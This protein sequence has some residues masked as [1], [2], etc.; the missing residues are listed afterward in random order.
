MKRA[1]ENSLC[2]GLYEDERQIGFARIVTDY[3]RHACHC[4]VFVL[5]THRGKGLGKWLV[6]CA[7]ECPL[8]AGVRSI[9][10]DT[11][12]AQGLY[13]QFGFKESRA[14]GGQMVRRFDM[15]WYRPEMMVE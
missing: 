1:I 9:K 11:R 13:A 14:T 2:F 8:I 3:A 12:D 6:E 5:D 15:P 10:P 4:D 7:I